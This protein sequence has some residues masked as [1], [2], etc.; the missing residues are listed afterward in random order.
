[1]AHTNAPSLRIGLIGCGHWGRHVLRDLLTCGCEVE[2]VAV[3][4]DSA[5][6]ARNGRASRIVSRIS[7]LSQVDGVVVVTPASTHVQVI[8]DVLAQ[9]PGLPI[10]TEK[11]LTT[12]PALAR[13]VASTSGAHVFVM[14]KWRYHPGVLA[15]AEIARSSE[16]GPVVGVRVVREQWGFRRRDVDSI[17]THFTHVLSIVLEVLGNIPQPLSAGIDRAGADIAGMTAHLGTAPWVAVHDSVRARTPRRELHLHCEG[18]TASLDD[19]YADGIDVIRMRD[20]DAIGG[21]PA[22]ERRAIS[23]KLPLLS[24]IEVFLEFVRGRGPAP[25][26]TVAEDAAIVQAIASLRTLAGEA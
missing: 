22:V 19:S 16:L 10:Y 21:T 18:G 11:P 5:A 13:R 9:R 20:L 23:T 2:V 15:L 25:K 24:Q 7:E 17:W 3:S 8:E 4:P 6:N 1:M 14:H 26:G 12:D